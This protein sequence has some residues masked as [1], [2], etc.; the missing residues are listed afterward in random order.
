MSLKDFEIELTNGILDLLWRQ[1]CALGVPGNVP[2]RLEGHILDPE[3]LLAATMEFGRRDARLFDEVLDWLL[4]NGDLINV[5]RLK[6]ISRNHRFGT[7]NILSAVGEF[8]VGS[9][10][11]FIGW[12]TMV[13]RKP[14][15]AEPLV[16]F[17]DPCGDALPAPRDPDP[18]FEKFGL[19]RERIALKGHGLPF[20][21][22]GSP[23][24]ILRLRALFGVTSRCELCC[25][26]A[27]RTSLSG[28]EAAWAA[29]YSPRA[30][31]AALADM[32]R[33]G[34]LRAQPLGKEIRYSMAS[35][36]L[37]GLLPAGPFHYLPAAT[38]YDALRTVLVTVRQCRH[39]SASETLTSAILLE[40]LQPIVVAATRAGYP[41][42]L[43]A[44]VRATG[45]GFLEALRRD[46]QEI[47]DLWRP[48]AATRSAR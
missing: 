16:L 31:Q 28:T 48:V 21:Q 43:S 17:R 4:I 9:K 32:S 42:L 18:L 39:H 38:L 8:V 27:A 22:S 34:I 6:S 37:G 5:T 1:W 19:L 44:T 29:G 7:S 23:A 12:R 20:P 25:L 40:N 30:A 41:Q 35:G 11:T 13:D 36:S 3:A 45:D 10:R 15:R 46:T 2:E 33:S 47:L 24:A 14:A 26:L